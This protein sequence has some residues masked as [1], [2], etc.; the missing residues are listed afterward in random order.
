M[1]KIDDDIPY[2]EKPWGYERIFAHTDKYIGK[3]LYIGIK[4]WRLR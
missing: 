2:I 1:L 3:Y 4:I